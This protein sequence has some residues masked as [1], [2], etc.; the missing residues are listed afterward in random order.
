M[1]IALEIEE[2]RLRQDAKWGEQNHPSRFPGCTP[3]IGTADHV[4]AL[5]DLRFANKCGSWADIACEELAEAC[6]ETDEARVREELVQLA[7]VCVAW[8]EC[9][10]RRGV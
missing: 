2:E 7:A 3:L 1:N 4:R 5:C 10:D 9:I 8:I 6:D